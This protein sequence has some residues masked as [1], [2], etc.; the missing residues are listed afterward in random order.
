V[1]ELNAVYISFTEMADRKKGLTNPEIAHL[2]RQHVERFK[3]GSGVRLKVT[4][5]PSIQLISESTGLNTR[6]NLNVYSLLCPETNR[7]RS[8]PR[9][10]PRAASRLRQVQP[11]SETDGRPAWGIAIHKTGEAMPAETA[12]LALEADATLMGAVGLPEFDDRPA[13]KAA[14]KRLLGI[15]K[16]PRRICQ[17]APGAHLQGTHRFLTTEESPGGRDRSDHRCAN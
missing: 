9:G 16:T 4:H 13:G 1:E 5:S 17:S 12:K 15:R 8:D 6:M 3:P 14:G 2:V 11:H 7:C 10:R